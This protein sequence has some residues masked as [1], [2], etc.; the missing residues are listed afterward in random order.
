MYT[1]RLQT[2]FQ[3]DCK[4]RTWHD[5]PH[6]PVRVD[7]RVVTPWLAPIVWNGTFSTDIL[8]AQYNEKTLPIG[9]TTF[10]M[11]KYIVFL[12]TFI[13]TA[14]KFF[15]VGHK[16]NYYVFTDRINE[17]PQFTLGNG[18]QLMI[19]L[20]PAYKRWQDVSMRRM[21]IIRDYSQ[22]RFIHEVDHLVCVD[23]DMKFTDDVGMEIIGDLVGTLHPGFFKS[24]REEYPYERRALSEAYIPYHE[25]DY[26][27]AGGNFGGKVQEV[28]KLTNHCHHAVLADKANNIEARWH[29]ESYINKYFLHH[30]PTKVLSPE[31]IW[32]YYYGDP[33]IV[34][35]KR[36][37][38][39]PKNR[40]WIRY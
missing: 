25:G 15:M 24:S 39:V 14:E 32:L 2:G 4:G 7:V 35:K 30:K 36:F 16:V 17:V 20:L 26:Y 8:N 28:I 23:V 22:Q 10:A 19:L 11:K 3:Y 40:A 12:K 1:I 21:E 33:P 6:G 5:I 34:Q 29:D 9:L 37:V 38:E 13:E 27:Y 31:Y 18:R